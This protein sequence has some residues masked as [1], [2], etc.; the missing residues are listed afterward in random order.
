MDKN[1]GE[2]LNKAYEAFRQACMDRDSAVKELQQKTENYEQRI[3]EQQEQLSLQQTIIDKLKSQLL[4][5]NSTQ[6]GNYGCVPLLEDSETRKNNLTV[7]Q[8]HN[9]VISGIA[10]EKLPKV[11]IASAESSIQMLMRNLA[12]S[13]YFSEVIYHGNSKQKFH[14]Y[15]YVT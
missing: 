2:Q 4:L 13:F 8:P 5:V 1:I 9:K 12:S 3:R 11:D 14:V 10:K 15:K 7:D 6:D